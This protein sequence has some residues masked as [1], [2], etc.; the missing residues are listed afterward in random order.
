MKIFVVFKNS[1]LET[2]D[3]EAVIVSKPVSFHT[4]SKKA[5]ETIHKNIE[6]EIQDLLERINKA[7]E[8]VVS[9]KDTTTNTYKYALEGR[10]ILFD[11][12]YNVSDN[13]VIVRT[14]YGTEYE[15]LYY[16]LEKE[17]E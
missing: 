15:N 9:I 5:M 16:M 4:D 12:L 17:L 10:N 1:V 6:E 14:N 13:N 11:N 7:N 2:I 8:D 3:D